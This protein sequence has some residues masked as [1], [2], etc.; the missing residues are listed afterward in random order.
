MQL[1]KI[2]VRKLTLEQINSI[3]S[4]EDKEDNKLIHSISNYEQK[5]LVIA[6]ILI[7]KN[8]TEKFYSI[9]HSFPF[10]VLIQDSNKCGI[11]VQYV[12]KKTN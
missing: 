12:D 3:S 6:S 5:L 11:D 10:C 7:K 2:D 1:E 4:T 9:S 8:I